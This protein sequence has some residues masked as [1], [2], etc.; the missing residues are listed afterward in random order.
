MQSNEIC[1]VY[2]IELTWIKFYNIELIWNEKNY[3]NGMQKNT[4]HPENY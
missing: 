2:N 4:S 1:S 3:L